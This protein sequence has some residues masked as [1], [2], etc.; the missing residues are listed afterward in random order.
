MQG[1]PLCPG[2]L[3]DLPRLATPRCP[4]CA[5]PTAMGEVCGGCL[6]HP[7]AFDVTCAVYRY[8]YPL[9]ALLQHYKYG[10]GLHLAGFL[11]EQLAGQIDSRPDLLIPMPLHPKRLAERGYNQAGEIAKR[12]ARGLAL[13]VSLSACI[14]S[15]NAPPQAS[16]PLKDRRKN[17][18]GAFA[19]REDL[20]GKRIALVDDVMTTGAS[21]N[22]LAKTVKQAG[23]VEVQAWVVARTLPRK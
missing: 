14:R 16:L 7:P 21:L 10:Q 18:R 12:L 17:I 22:E 3:A 8:A 6:K 4:V 11:A 5:L 13:P 9:D 15:R 1:A 19:C 2:C 23:A 20:S